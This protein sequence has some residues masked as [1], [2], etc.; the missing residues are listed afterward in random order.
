MS[1]NSRN[2]RPI[3]SSRGLQS[4]HEFRLPRAHSQRNECKIPNAVWRIALEFPA[5][6][7]NATETQNPARIIIIIFRRLRT[8]R[9]DALRTNIGASAIKKHEIDLARSRG[10][11]PQHRRSI[12]RKCG[13]QLLHCFVRSSIFCCLSDVMGKT[14]RRRQQT[15]GA[16]RS[17]N[18]EQFPR[19][20]VHF[21]KC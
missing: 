15:A 20:V 18:R 17:A 14:R 21:E 4:K 16:G 13:R 8:R 3:I 11:W 12:E 10:R 19:S 7:G 1:T 6:P 9:R 5:F 2:V